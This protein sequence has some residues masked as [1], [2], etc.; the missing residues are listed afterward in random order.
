M[1]VNKIYAFVRL[2]FLFDFEQM[3]PNIAED[4]ELYITVENHE[5]ADMY[6][7]RIYNRYFKPLY[8]SFLFGQFSTNYLEMSSDD[9]KKEFAQIVFQYYYVFIHKQSSDVQK[10]F[11]LLESSDSKRLDKYFVQPISPEVI[12][13]MDPTLK[14]YE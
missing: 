10:H 11:E 9:F 5:D 3:L 2:N 4:A 1:E 6:T 7:F 13:T 14:I 12:R 8:T